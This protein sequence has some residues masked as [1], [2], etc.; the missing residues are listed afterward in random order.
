MAT[1]QV[2]GD[3]LGDFRV[4][5]ELYE[6][7]TY[8]A[9]TDG[10]RQVVLKILEADCLLK[11]QLHPSVRDRLA[12]VR[13]LPHVGVANLLGVERDGGRTFLV[14]EYVRGVSLEQWA[15]APGQLE[16]IARE[17][18]LQVRWL[19]ACGIVHGAIHGRNVFILPSGRLRMTH[20]SPYLYH[21][22]ADDAGPLIELLRASSSK[23]PINLRRSPAWAPTWRR[24]SNP[25]TPGQPP[26][27]IFVATG[28][29]GAGPWRWPSASP[30]PR[31]RSIMKSGR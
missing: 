18:I 15:P 5:G 12:R 9:S 6:N 31:R 10:G 19:H 25:T 13:E 4:T 23:P 17:L 21:D 3:R 11:N 22:E 30:S 8:L 28:G 7:Q 14:W 26:S 2:I 24:G 29:G 20:V 16:R 1:A 27:P